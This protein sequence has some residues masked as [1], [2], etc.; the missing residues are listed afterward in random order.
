MLGQAIMSVRQKRASDYERTV[1]ALNPG[2]GK[3]AAKPKAKAKSKNAGK[4]VPASTITP[5]LTA[6]DLMQVSDAQTLAENTEN[7][8]T[9]G[10]VTTAANAKVRSGDLERGRVRAVSGANDDAAARGLY[11]SGIRAGNVGMAN[12]AAARGQAGV[13]NELAMA[14]AGTNAKIMAAR[15]Q[16][17][18]SMQAMTARAAENGAALPV[19]PYSTGR[20]QGANVPGSVTKRKRRG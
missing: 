11:Q 15:N 18:R 13:N 19:D 20:M 4:K 12:A 8:A 17:A 9:L 10:L 5:Y 14:G 16:L 6:A 1:A 2:E 3:A 7:D